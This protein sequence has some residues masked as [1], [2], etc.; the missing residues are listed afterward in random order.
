MSNVVVGLNIKKLQI[1]NNHGSGKVLISE[2]SERNLVR[3]Q[4]RIQHRI[5]GIK[6]DHEFLRNV[7][8]IGPPRADKPS[9]AS[10]GRGF[11]TTSM[12]ILPA[13]A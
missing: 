3:F 6:V 2:E 9:K 1:E 8:L 11:E 10:L 5:Y 12:V 7:L 13:I 4:S